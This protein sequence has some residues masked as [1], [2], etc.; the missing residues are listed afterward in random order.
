[1]RQCLDVDT[2][3]TR[4]FAK[5]IKIIETSLKPAVFTSKGLNEFFIETLTS[6]ILLQP[7][8]ETLFTTCAKK[9]YRSH[10]E[11]TAC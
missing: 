4:K 10:M 3:L 11:A 1:M 5:D 8:L 6:E 2:Q 7:P 9:F